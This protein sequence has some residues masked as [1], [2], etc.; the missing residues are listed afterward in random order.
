MKLMR[1]LTLTIIAAIVVLPVF[2]GCQADLQAE[3]T[4]AKKACIEMMQKVPVYYENFEFWD[5]RALSDDPDLQ[6]MYQVWY[7]RKVAYLEQQ[8]GIRSAGIDYLSQ[9]DG[10]L[11]IIIADYDVSALRDRLAV[12]FYRDTSYGYIEVWKSES[13]HGPQSFTGGWVLAEGLIVRGAN[14]SNVDDYL[15]VVSGDELSMYDKNAAEVLER[16]PEGIMTKVSR[17]GYPESLIFAGSSISKEEKNVLRW[18]NIYKFESPDDVQSA[19]VGKYF[20]G[21]EDDFKEAESIFAEHGEASLFN[22][23]T[24]K[25]DGEFVTWSML[26]DEKYMIALLFYG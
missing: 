22:T 13:S 24:I 20:K 16:L 26:I 8:Q 1:N 10:L 12:D 18:T 2:G 6:E 25:R 17:S 19:E 15:R 3:L 9:G 21:I 14:V 11:D 5:V 7:K 4:P 23:F